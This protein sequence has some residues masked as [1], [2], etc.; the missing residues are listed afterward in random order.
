MSP[1]LYVGIRF[2]GAT[3]VDVSAYLKLA[4]GIEYSDGRDNESGDAI[5]PGTIGLTLDN[6]DGRFSPS[7]P[8][9]PYFPNVTSGAGLRVWGWFNGAWRSFFEGTVTAWAADSVTDSTG[10][11]AICRVAASDSLGGLPGYTFH[12]A[13]DEHV[14]SHAGVVLHLPLRESASPASALIGSPTIVDNGGAGWGEGTLLRMDE[15]TD[16]HPLF[17]SGSGGLTLTVGGLSVG[18]EWTALMVLTSAPTANCALMGGFKDLVTGDAAKLTF[19]GGLLQGGVAITSYPAVVGVRS[20]LIFAGADYFAGSVDGTVLAV[21]GNVLDSPTKIIINPTL[22]GGAKWGAGHLILIDSYVADTF[23]EEFAAGLLGTRATIWQSAITTM[24]Y[25]AGAG[26]VVGDPGGQSVLPMLDGRSAADAISALATGM[27]ARLVDNKTGYL[28]WVP[29]PPS[30][31]PVAIPA[32]TIANDLNWRDDNGTWCSDVTLTWPDGSTYTATR[33]DGER[34]TGPALEGVHADRASDRSYADW[35]VNTASNG[36]RCPTVTVN[37]L[38]PR[39]TEPQRAALVNAIPGSRITF[40]PGLAWMP[41]TIIG[42]VEG[43]DMTIS[44]TEWSI[45]F[46]L[47]P[48]VYSTLFILD[49]PVQGVLDSGFLLAP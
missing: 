32:G 42:I 27:G 26:S 19:S 2:T 12:Q 43:R 3:W 49:D 34:K 30:S 22:S 11:A 24:L 44:H 37:L 20:S 46:K 16:N 40:S 25:Y 48:D 33:P 23:I 41:T 18:D 47:S 35:L 29:F 15:G 45:T 31:A 36:A 5:S 9:S 6:S 28:R 4:R 21:S 17:T 38:N 39:L 10:K 7:L 14:K 13:S 8:A 1:K